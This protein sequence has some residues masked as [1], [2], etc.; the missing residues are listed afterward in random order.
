MSGKIPKNILIHIFKLAI[1]LIKIV[2]CEINFD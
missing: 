2:N 1:K